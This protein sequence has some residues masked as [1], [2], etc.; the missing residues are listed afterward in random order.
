MRRI[1]RIWGGVFLSETQAQVLSE[2]IL[3]GWALLGVLEVIAHVAIAYSKC[4]GRLNYNELTSRSRRPGPAAAPGGL[5]AVRGQVESEDISRKKKR[6][7]RSLE[8]PTPHL[9]AAALVSVFA[10]E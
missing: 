2:D 10:V 6:A 7:P 9:A 3:T 1:A 8:R 4:A 5:A